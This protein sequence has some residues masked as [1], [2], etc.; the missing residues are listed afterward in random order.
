MH[1]QTEKIVLSGL[2]IAMGIVLAPVFHSAGLGQA[3]SPLHFPVLIAG[4][5]VGWKY[6]LAIGIITPL[7]SFLMPFGIP[8]IITAAQ[9]SAELAVY[10][11][12]IGLIYKFLKPFKT[13]LFN[14]YLSLIIAMLA[15]RIVGGA[16]TAL[17][18]GLQGSTY[19]FQAFLGAY[20]VGTFPAI[21]LQILIVP[22][23]IEI[24]ENRLEKRN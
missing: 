11:L 20:F 4:F 15:G 6:A 3:I 14:I 17:T 8:D 19:G 1:K 2:F 10:G 23:I 12:V 24:Y 18:F 13:R 22:A 7:L 21:I 9:I 5:I 16:V